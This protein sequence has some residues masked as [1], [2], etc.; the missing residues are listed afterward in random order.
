MFNLVGGKPGDNAS[1][2][3]RSDGEF[4]PALRA[5]WKLY[6]NEDSLTACLHGFQGL[7]YR[8]SILRI[9]YVLG[10]IE[11][12]F[13]P[14]PRALQWGDLYSRTTTAIAIEPALPL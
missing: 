13:P 14:S 8:G 2:L 4:G 12:L 7:Y 10:L 11:D 9:V 5:G 1:M 6:G 3:A